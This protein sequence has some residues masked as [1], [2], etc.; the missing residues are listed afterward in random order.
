MA[1]TSAGFHPAF[2]D[3]RN[4]DACNCNVAAKL[5]FGTM[6]VSGLGLPLG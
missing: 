5:D 2:G 4:G 1:A 3:G 6:R